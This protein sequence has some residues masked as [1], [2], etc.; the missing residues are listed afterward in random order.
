M[1]AFTVLLSLIGASL[2]QGGLSCPSAG[3]FRDP[4]DCTKFYRCVDE[5]GVGQYRAY[6]FVCPAGTVF[7]EA[8]SVCNWPFLAA[9]CGP[10]GSNNG[11]K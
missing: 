6:A 2:G 9:P 10:G 5:W 1:L 7:D 4:A 3:Y 11:G 8:V